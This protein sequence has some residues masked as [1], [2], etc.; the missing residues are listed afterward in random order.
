MSPSA[1]H[2]KLASCPIYSPQL[3]VAGGG[4]VLSAGRYVVG[5]DNG[6]GDGLP[7]LSAYSTLVVTFEARA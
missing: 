5:S 6:G 7:L 1:S 4:G 2:V 3:P